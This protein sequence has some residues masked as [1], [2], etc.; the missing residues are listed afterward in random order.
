MTP[1]TCTSRTIPSPIRTWLEIL[2]SPEPVTGYREVRYPKQEAAMQKVTE[3]QHAL[4]SGT[5][6]DRF[7][8]SPHRE[9]TGQVMGTFRGAEMNV[10]Q[11]T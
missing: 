11:K 6:D 5:V 7:R 2:R 8:G 4:A 9:P 3:L 10:G 1:A